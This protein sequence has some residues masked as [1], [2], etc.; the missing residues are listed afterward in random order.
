MSVTRIAFVLSQATADGNFEVEQE[1]LG[2]R[3]CDIR[4]G[5]TSM[6]QCTTLDVRK[7]A[8]QWVSERA[9]SGADSPRLTKLGMYVDSNVTRGKLIR[10][11]GNALSWKQTLES[12]KGTLIVHLFAEQLVKGV[13]LA[14]ARAKGHTR[15]PL[16]E[17]AV[18]LNKLATAPRRDAS[19][20][21]GSSSTTPNANVR[22]RG[23]DATAA[24]GAN[25]PDRDTNR[26]A[27]RASDGGAPRGSALDGRVLGDRARA[28]SKGNARDEDSDV[29]S[30]AGGG[31]GD[32]SDDD[33]VDDDDEF[34]DPEPDVAGDET[35]HSSAEAAIASAGS[36]AEPPAEEE[37][38]SDLESLGSDIGNL[39][40][41][42]AIDI[43]GVLSSQYGIDLRQFVSLS[44]EFRTEFC[45]SVGSVMGFEEGDPD[46]PREEYL[47]A[48]SESQ[49]WDECFLIEGGGDATVTMNLP[50]F[51]HHGIPR[52][53]SASRAALEHFPNENGARAMP[54]P[55]VTICGLCQRPV[56]VPTLG[57]LKSLKKH[58]IERHHP[59]LGRVLDGTIALADM[60][61]ST[62]GGL[63]PHHSSAAQ[64]CSNYKI[65][66]EPSV[67]I[68][69]DKYN[70][71][72]PTEKAYVPAHPPGAA[73]S[74]AGGR[75]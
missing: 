38:D 7:A 74:S 16:E 65:A 24:A 75:A 51:A 31:G 1:S 32:G 50:A 58:M 34:E 59:D 62:D 17:V 11:S 15:N 67:A 71:S 53:L 10:L 66:P 60:D 42:M 12:F 19:F 14:S 26:K 2:F 30:G 49:R 68:T 3:A 61:D 69:D 9:A 54:N 28:H 8:L 72:L 36:S 46:H 64:C 43:D 57:S 39:R 56:A 21:V 6:A 48:L 47:A 55:R 27:S 44:A 23:A 18:E 29:S 45:L 70:A 5:A 22:K 4:E 25:A 33:D 73:S 20:V 40:E 41:D 13:R 63:K 52:K 37:E 35:A